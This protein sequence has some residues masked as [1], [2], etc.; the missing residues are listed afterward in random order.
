[1]ANNEAAECSMIEV[2]NLVRHGD[3]SDDDG[4]DG[5][6]TA[7]SYDEFY[8]DVEHGAEEEKAKVHGGELKILHGAG[9]SKLKRSSKTSPKSYRDGQ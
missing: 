5:L 4:L 1:M 6:E 7:E 8:L 2:D 9:S 3:D